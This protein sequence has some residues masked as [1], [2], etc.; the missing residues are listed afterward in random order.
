[1]DSKRPQPLY[2]PPKPRRHC[3]VC[4]A[5]SYS[6]AGIH[7]QCAQKQADLQLARLSKRATGSARPAY[8]RPLKAWHKRCT[9]CGAQVHV[10]TATCACGHNHF[11]QTR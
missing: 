11:T 2:G 8:G 9:K 4:G 5:V 1:M 10:R 6:E 7:P 3:P